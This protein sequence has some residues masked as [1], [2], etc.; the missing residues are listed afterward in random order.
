MPPHDGYVSVGEIKQ[1]AKQNLM[2][3]TDEELD[4]ICR[5]R[6]D[7]TQLVDVSEN[8]ELFIATADIDPEYS[9][10]PCDI[11]DISCRF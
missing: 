11:L 3:F 7:D 8:P 2:D 1:L 5:G 6:K 10:N 9:A 4:F